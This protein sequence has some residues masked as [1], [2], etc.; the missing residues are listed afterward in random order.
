MLSG[1]KNKVKRPISIRSFLFFIP[2]FIVILTFFFIPVVITI[3]MG[4]TNM[5][6][7]FEWDFIGFGNYIK[8]F[9]YDDLLWP[10]WSEGGL[11]QP[12]IIVNTAVY[13]FFT[14]LIFNNLLG[15]ILA[16]TTMSIERRAGIF[17]RAVWLLPRFTPYVVYGIIWMAL[18]H[19]AKQGIFNIIREVLRLPALDWISA[20]PWAVMIITNGFVCAS[21][22]MVV[23]AA[24]IESIPADFRWAAK[25]DGAGWFQ[26]IR[27]LILPMIRWQVLFVTAYQTLSLLTSYEIIL[28]ITRGGPFYA[29]TVWS[30]YTYKIA[31]DSYVGTYKFGYAAALSTILVLIGIVASIFYW[32]TF[33][34]KQMMQ[35]P[36]IE[37]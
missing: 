33:K 27:Y 37:V 19:P 21:M 20:Y 31:F 16:I 14:L 12:N 9:K 15:V 35:E 18:L 36:K 22:G 24:A 11:V 1:D 34:F 6:F 13:V 28:V 10:I 7:K 2:A 25:V 30:L 8:M 3:T 17:F 5:D 4:F 32:R 23:F 29:T 26:E